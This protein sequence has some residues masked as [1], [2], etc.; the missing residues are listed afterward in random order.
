MNNELMTKMQ[1]E[2]MKK[3][4]RGIATD[5]APLLD[6]IKKLILDDAPKQ[7]IIKKIDCLQ[8]LVRQLEKFSQSV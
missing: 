1:N 8:Q 7:D 6:E 2:A 4:S 3:L 5:F